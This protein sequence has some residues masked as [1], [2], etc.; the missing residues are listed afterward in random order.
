[1]IELASEPLL[2]FREAARELPGSRHVSTLHRWRRCG[3]R[4]NKLETLVI[5]GRRYTSLAALQRFAQLTT[6]SA[7]GTN[8]RRS[9]GVG[10]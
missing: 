5:G 3:I 7:P 10:P 1:M 8:S 2:T 6:E 9:T 4:G